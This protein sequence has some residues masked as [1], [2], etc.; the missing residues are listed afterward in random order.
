[1]CSGKTIC[2]INIKFISFNQ[3]INMCRRNKYEAAKYKADIENEI[4]KYIWHLPA[5]EKVRI[6]FIWVEENRR[7]DLDNICF[8]KK[9]ILDALVKCG[10]LKNDGQSVVKGFTDEFKTGNKARVIIEV[11]EVTE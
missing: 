3:Y 2:E 1:M 11:E 10:K 7:R 6:K 4:I 5:F 8:A 9:F